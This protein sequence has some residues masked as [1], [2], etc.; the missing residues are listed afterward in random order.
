MV[1]RLISGPQIKS[2]LT[3]SLETA[4]KLSTNG[5]VKISRPGN[6]DL[7]FSE[8]LACPDCG[9]SYEEI[10]PRMFSF[11]NPFG[12]CESCS[13]L[14]YLLEIDPDLC[15]PDQSL[16]IR[17]G[18]IV[19]WNGASTQGSWNNQILISVCNH[20]KIPLDKPFSSVSEKHRR[21][22]FYGSG[23]EKITMQWET[24]SREG[25]GQFKRTFEGV[26]PNLLRRYKGTTSEDIR[27]WIESFMTQRQ[28]PTCKG[29]RLRKESLSILVGRRNIAEISSMSIQDCAA[30]FDSLK[31]GGKEAKIAFQIL[32]EIR[33]RID[34]LRNVGLSYLTL[35]RGASTLSGGEAQRIRLATQIG[36]RL[37]GVIYILDE[38]SIGLHP[39]DNSKLLDTLVALRD[40]GNTVV[41]IEHD[42][43]TMLSAD[44]LIDIGP[45]A[46]VH[47]G[48][49][50][51]Q[52]TPSQVCADR[53][54]LTGAYLSG[55]RE[56][57]IPATRR[58]GNGSFLTL[59]G[60]SGNNLKNI[61]VA[62]P[63]GMLVCVTG[64]SGSGKS[65]LIN[66]TLYP[67]LAKSIYHS[68]THPLPFQKI[69]GLEHIDKVIDIN[70]SPIG[71]TPRS[72]PATYT[73][74]MDMIR[75]L[76]ASLP[77]SKIRGYS[78]SRFSFNVKGGRCESCEGDGVLKIEMH[79]LPDVY[80]QCESCK[81]KR[82]NRETLEVLY[83]NK[84]IADVLNM[85]VDEALLFFDKIGAIKSR[86]SVLSQVGLGYIHLGQ[87]ATTLSGGE[88]QRIKLASELSK[89]ATG[90]TL[91]ILDEPTTGLH[92]EDILMFMNVIKEL[93]DKGNS[94]IIIEHNL[95]VIKCADYVIDLGPEGGDGGGRIV[96]SGTP[97][98]IS[99]NPRSI[100]GKYLKSALA[101]R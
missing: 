41:V 100:T 98:Q 97:E 74:T 36:S 54:S 51:S 15:V 20:F 77:E 7:V 11:N 32:K 80:V 21:I 75:N 44:H 4:L 10:T 87:P 28:C 70:Q 42:K 81:G 67:A 63:L 8:Q 50:I 68:K 49:I 37:T 39:R 60:A 2:R 22:L 85:T 61:D 33:Q 17:Q 25:K 57:P 12:A 19:P 82:Y 14:G 5:T 62:F 76:F 83:K 89:R 29:S 34:F 64:V 31:L 45:G 52:G 24:A 6:E 1:D 30:F 23:D 26:I 72:N 58:K 9:V 101:G 47:G 93:V 94:V 99:A 13:G 71:R 92:F 18:A 16:S 48:K 78:P 27:Q 38:P 35:S 91:Y 65:T 66:Q 56:I 69:T 59:K 88:A 84:S 53:S 55:R 73:K 96:A 79:F 43:E 90:R 3:D 95:D 86:L 46:G 40:L